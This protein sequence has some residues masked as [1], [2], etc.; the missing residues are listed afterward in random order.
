[1]CTMWGQ[2][3]SKCGQVATR[4]LRASL[5]RTCSRCPQWQKQP[6]S[7]NAWRRRTKKQLRLRRND[8][9]QPCFWL[10][11]SF[12]HCTHCLYSTL[13]CF[14]FTKAFFLPSAVLSTYSL[15]VTCVLL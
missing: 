11:M 14:L 12:L 6:S 15:T 9:E 4:G 1:M 2:P 8:G 5:R 7:L 10:Y 13:L 3:R